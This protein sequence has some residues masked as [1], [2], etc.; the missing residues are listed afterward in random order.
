M[1]ERIN[2]EDDVGV[3]PKVAVVLVHDSK[4]KRAR[5]NNTAE[6]VTI[7]ISELFVSMGATSS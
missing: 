5:I 6:R 2:Q 1:D 7:K 4:G 3:Y